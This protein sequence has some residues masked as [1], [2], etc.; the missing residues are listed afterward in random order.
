MDENRSLE[1]TIRIPSLPPTL[2][3]FEQVTHPD[4][5]D[6]VT[7]EAGIPAV[8]LNFHVATHADLSFMKLGNAVYIPVQ[9]TQR[10]DGRKS[11]YFLNTNEEILTGIYVTNDGIA[12]NF[13]KR[14]TGNTMPAETKDRYSVRITNREGKEIFQAQGELKVIDP[15]HE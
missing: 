11:L 6:A 7:R 14:L 5:I 1:D 2:E 13:I 8:L 3:K 9:I 15:V 4:Q 12:L 10:E